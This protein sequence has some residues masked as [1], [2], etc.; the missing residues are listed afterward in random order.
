MACGNHHVVD[1]LVFG[2]EVAR[3]ALFR[4]FDQVPGVVHALFQRRLVSLGEVRAQP[5]LRRP[6]TGLTTHTVFDLIVS[7]LDLTGDT[8]RM[9]GQA[10][11]TLF[12]CLGQLQILRDADRPVYAQGL[13]GFGMLIFGKPVRIF[14]PLDI[15]PGRLP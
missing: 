10:F 2:T 12:G 9:A 6:M 1:A 11:H 8:Q 7:S 3:Q 4:T 13:I 14:C 5:A 15:A